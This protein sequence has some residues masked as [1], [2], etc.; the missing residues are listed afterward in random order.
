MKNK[1][2]R[3]CF[4]CRSCCEK[5]ALTR[6]VKNKDGEVFIDRTYKANGRGAYVCSSMY[7]LNKLKKHKTL[8][9]AFKCELE[10]SIIEK[11]CEEIIGKD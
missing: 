7:C 5:S 1:P 9:K 3:M 10:Q 2:I 11:I 6:I 8:N 4:I